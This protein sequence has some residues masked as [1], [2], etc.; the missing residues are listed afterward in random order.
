MKML[1][2]MCALFTFI[3]FCSVDSINAYSIM[4]HKEISKRLIIQDEQK[5]NS[6]LRNIGL[7]KGVNEKIRNSFLWEK[8][9]REWIEYGSWIEDFSVDILTSHFYDPLT[10]KGYSVGGVEIGQSAYDRANDLPNYGPWVWARKRLYDGL[11][12]TDKSLREKYLSIA[13]HALGSAMHLVQDVSVPAHTRN[14]FPV[15]LRSKECTKEI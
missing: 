6:Y 5:L 14:D 12:Q 9:V 3:I 4:V 8:T 2:S 7:T 1:F 10:N 13:F 15:N 11:T